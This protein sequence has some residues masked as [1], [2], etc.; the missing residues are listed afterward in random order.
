MSNK[1]KLYSE[2]LTASDPSGGFLDLDGKTIVPLNFSIADIRDVSKR[3]GTFSKSITLPGTK[4][5]NILLNNYFDVNIEAGTF[6]I[7]RLQKCTVIQ[8]DVIVLENAVMQLVSVN[9]VQE[10]GAYESDVTYTV[11]I[12]DTTAD[13]F[14]TISNKTLD[15]LD[16]SGLNHLYTAD[17]VVNSFDNTIADGYKYVMPYNAASGNNDAQYSLVEFTPA[18]YAKQYWDQ[19]FASAGFTY[20]WP[21]LTGPDIRFDKLL[22]P[23]N[24]D[25][26]TPVRNDDSSYSFSALT[27]ALNIA[28]PS[29]FWTN[30][31]SAFP[32][33][34]FIIRSSDI[35]KNLFYTELYDNGGVYDLNNKI[36]TSP[37]TPGVTNNTKFTYSITYQVKIRNTAAATRYLV[38]KMPSG[39]NPVNHPLRVKPSLKLVGGDLFFS[40][41]GPVVGNQDLSSAGGDPITTVPHLYSI[42]GSTTVT[43]VDKRTVT[44]EFTVNG[45]VPL[46]K[47][48]LMNQLDFSIDNVTPNFVSRPLYHWS[49]SNTN[50]NDYKRDVYF[51]FVIQ[52]IELSSVVQL[53]GEVSYNVPIHMN[54]FIPQNIKQ[55]DF[56]KGI[57]TMFNLYAEVDD[58][59]S[60]RLNIF[61]RDEYYDSGKVENWTDKLDKTKPQDL[62]FLPEITNKKLLLTY[63]QD[64]DW[65]NKNYK[66]NTNEVYGQAEYVFDNEYVKDTTKIELLFSPT[67]TAN[68][69]FGAVCPIWNGQAPKNNIRILYDGG[70]KPCQ[71]YAI[72]NYGIAAGS[73]GFTGA[74][75]S[76]L[77]LR[78]NIQ[79]YPFIGHWDTPTNPSFDL[80]FLPSDYYY[81]SDNW[82]INTNNNLF[83]LHWRRTVNQL[84][85]GKLLSA[86]FVLNSTDIQKMKLNDKIRIDNS[87]WNINKIQDYDANSNSSTKVELI[88]VDDLLSPPFISVDSVGVD[89]TSNL[90]PDIRE[91][92]YAQSR[93]RNTI[94]SEGDI[95]VNGVNNII[96]DSVMTGNVVGDNNTIITDSIV[97]G[98]S[99]SAAESTFIIGDNNT[100]PPGATNVMI[101]GSGISASATG[102]ILYANNIEIPN[103]GTINGIPVSSAISGDS[104]WAAGTT[105]QAIIQKDTLATA[106][107]LR[108][109]SMGQGI[110]I[111]GSVASGPDSV[112]FAGGNASG[113]RSFAHGIAAAAIEQDSVAFTAGSASGLNSF[114]H[115]GSASGSLASSFS[116]GAADGG[117]SHAVGNGA[118]AQTYS[119]TVVGI[120]ASS[121]TGNSGAYSAS[122]PAFRVGNGTNSG[123][124]S[125]AFRVYKNGA[126]YFKPISLASVTSPVIGMVALDS[127]DNTLKVYNGSAWVSAAA[128]GMTYPTVVTSV[129]IDWTAPFIYNTPT[130]PGTGNI[131]SSNT[132][133]NLGIVQKIYHNAGTAPTVPA[134]W[135]LLSG[136]YTVSQ[137][138]IIYAEY[139]TSTRVEYWI[140]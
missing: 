34:N 126:S 99:N 136:T 140:I 3:K 42:P 76:G 120:N 108:A 9:K 109:I 83:N 31:D 81:R 47:Y 43:L 16:F 7:N 75:A 66:D 19:I 110:G 60:N 95:R 74:T 98:N 100:V 14:S 131:T 132:G 56:I 32:E 115:A 117:Y 106:T 30:N 40:N 4:N 79:T 29:S 58:E 77:A 111:N 61:S 18:I 127:S 72:W 64:S 129:S 104:F 112:A 65:A 37:N 93:I 48:A 97:R 139:S 59:V 70:P 138:N 134:N 15:Q 53:E 46:T 26:P 62:K 51:D 24:G 119:E 101:V 124:R 44:G 12:K 121:I 63:K 86:Y 133:A 45:I 89:R 68:T 135:V 78:N 113:L 2:S 54:K 118:L 125:D 23:Y 20:N 96:V 57:L 137:L 73:T 107:G 38:G 39:F 123:S 67:P 105:A 13:F 102:G 36:Y 5:N 17:A 130:S 88:S 33:Y 85:T 10:N 87:W 90:W 50:L 116:G 28:Y 122:D 49:G 91:I 22:I 94:Y 71:P 84:N 69:S 27:A 41:N 25:V 52:S 128:G 11:V 55:N 35:N 114:S 6:D 82:G 80:Q 21:G 92:S 103:G 8:D 1:I